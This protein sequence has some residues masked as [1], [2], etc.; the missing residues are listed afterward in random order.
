MRKYRLEYFIIIFLCI[1]VLIVGGTVINK[2]FLTMKP[3]KP[4]QIVAGAVVTQIPSVTTQITHVPT[5][6]PSSTVAPRLTTKK[7]QYTIAVYGDSMVE[8]MG[9]RTDYL[10]HKLVPTYPSTTFKFYNYG[11]GGENAQ[12]GLGRWGSAFKYKD[13]DFPPITDIKPDIIIIGSFAYNPPVPYDRNAHF[14]TLAELVRKA[15]STGA[16]VYLLAEIA[17]LENN[18]GKGP[19]GVNWDDS[20]S[21]DQ[22]RK[23]TELLENAVNLG[24]GLGVPVIN[25]YDA[26]NGSGK[27]GSSEYTDPHDGIHPSV[28]GH[29]FM[30]SIIANKLRL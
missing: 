3:Q 23:I 6:S 22:A 17:P 21:R 26:T 16:Q 2:Y 29:T 7:K 19:G 10:E 15:Q 11:V 5:A 28:A 1:A 12:K 24:S 4:D 8:T 13:R 25:V 27:Y 9:E 14:T 18:F 30:A 20:L